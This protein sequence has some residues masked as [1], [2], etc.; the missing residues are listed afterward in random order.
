MGVFSASPYIYRYWPIVKM[1]K[2]SSN[3]W[4][5]LKTG[6]HIVD[7][8]GVNVCERLCCSF[9]SLSTCT[10]TLEPLLSNHHS[11]TTTLE[12]PLSNHQSRTTTLEPPISNHQSRTTN[13]EP[14]LSNRHSRTTTLEPLLSNRHSRTTALPSADHSLAP[15]LVYFASTPQFPSFLP[16]LR[17]DLHRTSCHRHF[18]LTPPF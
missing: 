16:S 13:L 11:R 14:L 8:P 4:E 9:S 7:A 3:R 1:V 15:N 12:P 5:L 2:I 6:C 18:L 17:P 10:A